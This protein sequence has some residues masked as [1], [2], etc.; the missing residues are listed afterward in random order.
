MTMRIAIDIRRSVEENAAD[1]F[2]RA[3]KSKK[4]L[5]GARKALA[6][7]EQR[8]A[9][10][11]VENIKT[12]EHTTQPT[13]RKQERKQEWYE[14]LRWFVS[15]DGI[16][17]IGGRDAGTNE[18]VVKKHAEKG[19]VVFHTDMAGSPFVVVKAEGKEVPTTTLEE[20][21]QF[22]ASSVRKDIPSYKAMRNRPIS[23]NGSQNFSIAKWMK[24]SRFS[25][26]AA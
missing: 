3:K 9:A 13:A 20:A 10:V 24:S 12:T 22:C 17:C 19:D 18:L 23:R 8:L 6:L 14:K 5:E 15:S 1:H 4:K 21:A 16:I 25:R 7:A 26:R 11:H 2:E